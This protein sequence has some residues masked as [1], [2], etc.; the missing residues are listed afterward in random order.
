MMRLHAETWSAVTRLAPT[1]AS[2]TRELTTCRP[3]S[4][5][6]QTPASPSSFPSHCPTS[7]QSPAHVPTSPIPSLHLLPTSSSSPC[8][9]SP[10]PPTHVPQSSWRSHVE[11]RREERSCRCLVDPRRTATADWLRKGKTRLAPRRRRRGRLLGI[12]S[13]GK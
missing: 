10:R 6:S 7:C 11:Q 2:P 3:R 4:I 12:D 1:H 5:P 9:P 13:K 8:A